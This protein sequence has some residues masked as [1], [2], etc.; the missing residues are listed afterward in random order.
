MVTTYTRLHPRAAFETNH[1]KI[2]VM[3]TAL[4]EDNVTAYYTADEIA[5]QTDIA[6]STVRFHLQALCFYGR[7]RGIRLR[8][9]GK[10]GNPKWGYRVAKL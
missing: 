5:D 3:L 8:A 9:P 2:M 4:C 1:N 6:E 10:A 7:V